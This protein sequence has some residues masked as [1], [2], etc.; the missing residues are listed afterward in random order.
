[1][2]TDLTFLTNEPNQTLKDRFHVLVKDA[3]FFDV[4]VGY[5][6]ASGFSAIYPALENTEKIRILVGIGT[7]RQMYERFT[8]ARQE[9]QMELLLSHAEA[10]QVIEEQVAQEL[11]DS[12]DNQS[13]EQGVLKFIEWIRSGKLEIRAYPSQ[14]I[15]AKVYIVTFKEDERDLGRVITG[16]SNLTQTGLVDNL[17][18]NV[19]LKNSADYRFAR[20]KFEQLWKDGVELSEKYLQTIETR[21]WLSADILPY[22]LYLKLLYEYFKDELNRTEDIFANYLPEGFL[23]LEYQQQAVLNAKKILEEY[24]FNQ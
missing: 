20:E 2:N 6:F 21:T 9:R 7:D 12:P 10:K 15:H 14:N 19:E 16:S 22:H 18:F 1:M 11:E 17:E 4:L 8:E 24:G 13:V 23:K 5:F 3:R